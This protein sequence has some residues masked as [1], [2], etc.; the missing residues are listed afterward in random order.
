M[1]NVQME[2]IRAVDRAIDVLNAFNRHRPEMTIDE[3]AT[4]TKL[5]RATAYRIL[6]TLERRGLIR[7]DTEKLTYRLGLQFLSYG[8]LVASSLNL[9]QEAEDALLR[10]YDETRQG[11]LLAV[12][13]GDTL[14]YIFRKENPEG[15]KVASLEGR[16]RPLVF[17]AFGTVIMAYLDGAR[18]EE[19]L[20]Q[21]IPQ[22]T[23][24]TVTNPDRIR[25]R[26]AQV[27]KDAIWVETDEAILGVTGIAAPVFD[28]NGRFVGAA[29][30]DGPT[31]QLSGEQ[32]A[33]AKSL[34]LAAAEEISTQ[35]GHS[36]SQRR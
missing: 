26:L 8:D 27:R 11:V 2:S 14:V 13:Q 21:P 30:L 28:A 3:V 20:A 7:F 4:N 22:F 6:Y 9:R 32:L 23:P 34:V 15:L 1:R 36:R 12:E 18:L 31:V 29:G 5:P 33:R 16:T 10:L 19:V 25:D 24:A 35:L 17:G